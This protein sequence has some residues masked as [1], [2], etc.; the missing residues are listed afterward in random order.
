MH[1]WFPC[2]SCPSTSQKFPWRVDVVST[3]KFKWLV[4]L[5]H[6]EASFLPSFEG[7]PMC[8][9]PPFRKRHLVVI[10]PDSGVV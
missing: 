8:M 6:G 2:R 1:M 7:F 3:T 9:I 5:L 4:H 10:T